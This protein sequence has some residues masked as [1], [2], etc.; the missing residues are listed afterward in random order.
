MS[1]KNKH[2]LFVGLF[3]LILPLSAFGQNSSNSLLNIGVELGG[4]Y[5]QLFIQSNSPA[6]HDRTA[7]SF[8]P[9]ARL[10]MHIPTYSIF[11]LYV[12]AGYNEFGG[13]DSGDYP[14][15]GVR[16]SSQVKIQ[17][18]DFGMF[19]LFQISE[20]KIGFGAKYNHHLTF[21]DR[22]VYFHSASADWDWRNYDTFFADSSIDG[23]LRAEYAIQD[24]FT[25]GAE[26]W[27]GLTDL[28]NESEAAQHMSFR[29]NHFRLLLG[30]RL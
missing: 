20:F 3:L 16:F 19:G 14:A 4:G 6:M 22:Y 5:N 15:G 27:F 17:A 12:F 29:Q 26:S 18:L 1:E 9:S 11:S 30:Y 7:F 2:T 8:M 10:S 23:G 25:I 24:R 21:S 28:Q 13:K